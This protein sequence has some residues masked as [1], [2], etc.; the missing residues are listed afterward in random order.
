MIGAF[1]VLASVLGCIAVASTP[2][3]PMEAIDPEG[4]RAQAVRR[5]ELRLA[6]TLLAFASFMCFSLA[7]LSLGLSWPVLPLL[8]GL[9][10]AIGALHPWL[11]V[12][13]ILI[14]SGAVRWAYALSRL[15]GHPWMRDPVG[16]S[17]LAGALAL[18]RRRPPREARIEELRALLSDAPLRGAGVVAAGLLE[19]AAGDRRAARKLLL[20]IDDLDP[21]VVPPR[22]RAIAIDWLVAD[23]ARE[24]RWDEVVEQARL[25][26]APCRTTRLLCECAQ[27]LA[28]DWVAPGDLWR[29]WLLAPRR[30]ITFSLVRRA[31]AASAP[32]QLPIA[33]E[34]DPRLA[35][36]D[37]G[38]DGRAAFALHLETT[39][40]HAEGRAQGGSLDRLG[41]A[42][43]ATLWDYDFR[44]RVRAR[45]LDLGCERTPDRI[46]ADLNATA[47]AEI[48]DMLP[49]TPPSATLRGVVRKASIELQDRQIASLDIAAT[50][51]EKARKATVV[52]RALVV[53]RAWLWIR[54]EYEATPWSPQRRRRAYAAIERELSR[55]ALWLWEQR[56]ERGLANA[57]SIWLLRE[58][59]VVDDRRA[60]A[61][62]RHV[63]AAGP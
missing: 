17:V 25:S 18:L 27:R 50:Q 33:V 46:V 54:A 42:W 11:L 23:A 57:I 32:T 55:T 49:P 31:L 4:S 37:G 60:A 58:A 34:D 10:V 39:I 63:V 44:R 36:N 40:A 45:A 6:G 52:P 2:L 30:H 48:A 5:G 29:A 12:R 59:E 3:P 56:D 13:R 22:A 28:G 62:H 35:A 53:W 20:S 16:G 9:I 26:P 7:A 47:A 24:G 8:L 61:H 21:E 19:A 14:P 38:P 41:R 1:V 15:G 51:L 43:D